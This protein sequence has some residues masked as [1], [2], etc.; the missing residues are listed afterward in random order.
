MQFYYLIYISKKE[1]GHRPIKRGPSA[2]GEVAQTEEISPITKL[3]LHGREV[4][5]V[6]RHHHHFLPRANR[7]C[8][9]RVSFSLHLLIV[10]DATWFCAPLPE[11][12]AN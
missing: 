9:P 7:S 6:L 5:A 10:L 8:M 12:N 11:A 1:Y 3:L 2:G 4:P